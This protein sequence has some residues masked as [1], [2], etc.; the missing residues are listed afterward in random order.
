MKIHVF[1]STFILITV[2]VLLIVVSKK[3]S[4]RKTTSTSPKKSPPSVVTKI[5][6]PDL[7]ARI[8]CPL[9]PKLNFADKKDLLY[10]LSKIE[11]DREQNLSG[12]FHLIHLFGPE[13]LAINSDNSTTPM[14]ELLLN[15]NLGEKYFKD[16]L[17]LAKT[18]WGLRFPEVNRW[19]LATQ[20][21]N[22]QAHPGQGLATLS[23]AGV[24]VDTT[25]ILPD[26][27]KMKV[28]DILDDVQANFVLEGD[29][30][31]DVIALAIYLAPQE[32]WT[33]KFGRTF[34][35]DQVVDELISR[36]QSNMLCA[37]THG[38][39]A[40]TTL[41]R[42]DREAP[43]LSPIHRDKLKQYLALSV[44][45][46]VHSQLPDGGWSR[47]WMHPRPKK[48][49]ARVSAENMIQATGHHLEWLIL[50]PQDLQ[51]EPYI[52]EHAAR[53]LVRL[54]LFRI[55]DAQWR[56]Q[57]FCPLTHAARSVS[58]LA[59]YSSSL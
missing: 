32:E 51:P 57:Y 37:G 9:S 7:V 56:N 3:T 39:I 12:I 20:Q 19:Y 28:K 13:A 48:E 38:L 52:L 40:L 33:D 31:W 59:G 11:E 1:K 44:E 10:I 58:I 50:L 45:Q 41:L 46:L 35:F 8:T 43:I 27:K 42:V 14:V 36:D 24:A 30:Y 2:L 23:T 54:L 22:T 55:D 18:R 29:I 53:N 47:Q 26:G 34:S 21:R 25:V 17:V 5:Q 6:T 49:S 15:G 16:G 4:L